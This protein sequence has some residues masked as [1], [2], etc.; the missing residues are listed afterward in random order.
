[1]SNRVAAPR[2]A[3]HERGVPRDMLHA[4]EIYPPDGSIAG[5]APGGKEEVAQ[6]IADRIVYLEEHSPVPV[7]VPAAM[8]SEGRETYG[9]IDFGR[10]PNT[11]DLGGL[12]AADGSRVKPGLLLRS[13]ALGFG[14]DADLDR[15]R[16]EYNLKLVVDLRNI[17]ELIEIPDPMDAFPG[18][19]YLHADILARSVEG[20]TQ[21]KA[22][23][24]KIMRERRELER[25]LRNDAANPMEAMYRYLLMSASGMLGYR[26]FMRALIECEDGAALWHCSIGRDRCGIASA[27]VETVLGVSWD[28]IE[29]D[30][31]ATNIF[32]TNEQSMSY[33]AARRALRAARDAVAERYGSLMGY[34]IT[35]LEVTPAEVDRLRARYLD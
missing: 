9:W 8:G 28:D 31:L 32:A 20:I 14:S 29:S 25:S 22:T 18:A 13:G 4:A 1:M 15:L 2:A 10:L 19:R 26:M 34:I 3:R 21:E 11:R 35:A 6:R 33:P 24:D 30:Y 23:R 5:A 12:S 7:E 17:E 16:D 27:L